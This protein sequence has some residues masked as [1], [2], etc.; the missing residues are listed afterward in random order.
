MIRKT[1]EILAIIIVFGVLGIVVDRRIKQEYDKG[2]AAGQAACEVK[3]S[4][5]ANMDHTCTAWFFDTNLKAA[6]ARMCGRRT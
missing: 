3:T 6:K 4:S 2:Y 5:R 1:A